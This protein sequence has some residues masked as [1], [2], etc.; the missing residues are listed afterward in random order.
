MPEH[1][2]EASGIPFDRPTE[3]RQALLACFADWEPELTELIHACDDSFLPRP[4]N[5]LP[6]GL[7]WDSQP[8]L[9]LLGDAAHLMSPFAG[10]GANLAMLDAA[11][12]AKELLA[13]HDPSEAI[14]TYETKMFARAKEA[15]EESARNL[16]LCIAPDGAERLAKQMAI[17]GAAQ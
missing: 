3:A 12:L 16:E 13:T 1:D 5:M 6:I 14:K 4:I 17:Y 11:E 8:A 10:A 15:A 2:L 7:T 9:T